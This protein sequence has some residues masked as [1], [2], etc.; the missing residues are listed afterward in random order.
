MATDLIYQSSKTYAHSVG[1]SCCF[2]QWRAESHCNKLHGYTLKV[3]VVFEDELDERNW[4]QDFGDLKALK[5]WLTHNFD[6]KTLVA[7]DD[8]EFDTFQQLAVKGII[9]VRFVPAVGC[10]KFAEQIFKWLDERDYMVKSVQVWEHEA[11]SAKV[12]RRDSE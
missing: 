12:I 10:E 7:V 9:D 2:R 11:N 4:V 8:P 5:D 6:H 1:L 3:E